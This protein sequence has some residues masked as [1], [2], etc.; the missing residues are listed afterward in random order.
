MWPM[1]LAWGVAGWSLWRSDVSV[2][3]GQPVTV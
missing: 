1:M 3:A 2:P